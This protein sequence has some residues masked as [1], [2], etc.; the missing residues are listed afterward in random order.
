MTVLTMIISS[1]NA[2]MG[3]ITPFNLT[4]F[5][6]I[7]KKTNFVTQIQLTIIH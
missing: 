5:D 2:L 4:E 3:Q 7:H 1:V 6:Y